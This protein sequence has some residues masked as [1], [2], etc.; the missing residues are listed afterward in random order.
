MVR[1]LRRLSDW[2]K[3]H[4]IALAGLLLTAVSAGYAVLAYHR[5]LQS[6]HFP[7]LAR[8]PD[9]PP[10]IL[11]PPIAQAPGQPRVNLWVPVY[12]NNGKGRWV[13]QALWVMRDDGTPDWDTMN[14]PPPSHINWTP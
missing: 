2:L 4:W 1:K 3:L 5:P 8:V 14:A 12:D 9:A 6:L 10:V 11:P 13:H 7:A